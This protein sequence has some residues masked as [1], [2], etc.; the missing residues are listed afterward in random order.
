MAYAGSSGGKDQGAGTN[1]G[2]LGGGKNPNKGGNGNGGARPTAPLYP[3]HPA[4]PPKPKAPAS[5]DVVAMAAPF[6]VLLG[7]TG[8][9]RVPGQTLGSDA[10]PLL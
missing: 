4:A 10:S 9:G 6:S 5:V 8:R 2:D 1:K 7:P 3:P